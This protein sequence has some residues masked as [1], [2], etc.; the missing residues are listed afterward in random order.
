MS[1]GKV[2]IYEHINNI[3]KNGGLREDVVVRNFRIVTQHGVIP[4]KNNTHFLRIDSVK[5]PVHFLHKFKIKQLLQELE[6]Y[7]VERIVSTTNTDKFGQAL[8]AFAN[9]LSATGKPIAPNA[10]VWY[11]E[12]PEWKGESEKNIHEGENEGE[13][14]TVN[15]TVKNADNLV[16]EWNS[17]IKRN[18]GS[19][20][21]TVNGTD[22]G[23]NDGDNNHIIVL[24]LNHRNIYNAIKYNYSSRLSAL[25]TTKDNNHG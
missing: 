22:N 18:G 14:G 8:C 15:E 3:F 20:N 17:Q 11:R 2:I 4:D 21:E 1:N 24:G 19:E 16:N 25:T 9:D 13:N 12:Y 10:L 6:S 5:Q 7:R 23:I